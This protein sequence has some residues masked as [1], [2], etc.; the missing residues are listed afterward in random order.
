[1]DSISLAN[2]FQ[3]R[4]KMLSY[5]AGHHL[6]RQHVFCFGNNLTKVRMWWVI[7]GRIRIS[8]TELKFF[9]GNSISTIITKLTSVKIC[10][11]CCWIFSMNSIQNKL[12]THSQKTY[13]TADNRNKNRSSYPC[14]FKFSS[15]YWRSVNS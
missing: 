15:K 12:V 5:Y 11:G 8:A 14:P 9:L 6:H 7:S 3:P 4:D 13:K 2:T 1:M 10:I